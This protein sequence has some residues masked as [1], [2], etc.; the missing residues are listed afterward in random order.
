MKHAALFLVGLII[1]AVGAVIVANALRARDAYARGAMDVMQHHYGSLR[2]NLR[3]K[4]CDAHKTALA[5]SQLRALGNEIEPAVYPDST[6]E[7]SF[8]EFSSRLRDA[9]DA[10]IAAAPADCAALA[11]V[12]EK[13]GK[14]CEECH[15]QYR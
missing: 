1:G 7:S 8:R 2:E 4:R 13:V 14:V 11:P 9:L 3:A 12:V 5:L 6:P 15:Q 10:G